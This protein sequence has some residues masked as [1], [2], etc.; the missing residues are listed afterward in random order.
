MQEIFVLL[1]NFVC[2]IHAYLNAHIYSWHQDTHAYVC[3]DLCIYIL[4]QI[5]KKILEMLS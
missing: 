5:S 1:I 4:R 3:I 2:F